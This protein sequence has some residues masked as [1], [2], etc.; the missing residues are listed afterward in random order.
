LELLQNYLGKGE[1]EMTTCFDHHMVGLAN[2]SV[3][4]QEEP[5]GGGWVRVS[6]NVNNLTKGKGT[7]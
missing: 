7:P 1:H 6:G 4:D 2:S 3:M 5:R